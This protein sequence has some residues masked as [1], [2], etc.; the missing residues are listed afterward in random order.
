MIVRLLT[1]R[2]GQYPSGC[3]YYQEVGELVTVPPDEGRR[4][5]AANLAEVVKESVAETAMLEPAGH[6]NAVRRAY[7]KA[8]AR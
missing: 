1:S 8:D 5:I 6:G 4:M 3:A 2:V 7:R